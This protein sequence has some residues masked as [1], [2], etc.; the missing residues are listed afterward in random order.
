MSCMSKPP[1]SP[2]TPLRTPSPSP[3][4][5]C[6]TPEDFNASFEADISAEKCFLRASAESPTQLLVER[7]ARLSL[8]PSPVPKLDFDTDYDLIASPPPQRPNE[9]LKKENTKASAIPK[10]YYP[11]G[12]PVPEAV[13][14]AALDSVKQAFSKLPSGIAR[15]SCDL[16]QVCKAINF[17]VYCKRPLYEAIARASGHGSVTAE[18]PPITF[19]NFSSFWEEMTSK[20]HD[21]ASRFV[22]TLAAARCS[23]FSSSDVREYLIREDFTSLISDLISTHPGLDFLLDSPKFHRYYT[24]TVVVRIFWTVNRSFINDKIPIAKVRR[25]N[26]IEAIRKLEKTDDTNEISDFFSYAHFFVIYCTFHE[27]DRDGDMLLTPSDMRRYADGVLT[28]A[29]IERI[30]RGAGL[31]GAKT[32]KRRPVIGLC[33]FVAFMLAEVD[34]RNLASIDYWFRCLDVE[35]TG[36]LTAEEMRYFYAS[37]ESELREYELLHFSDV[38]DMLF[39]Y[40]APMKRRIALSD[41]RKCGLAHR[42]LNTFVNKEK[43]LEQE[44]TEGERAPRMSEWELFCLEEY[45]RMAAQDL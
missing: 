17:P 15:K 2:R 18:L 3:R 16:I 30:F 13:N 32:G 37:V 28:A 19:E 41:L 25:S 4:K 8:S 29:V 23:K 5:I 7:V 24:D 42:F 33:E 44:T 34:K 20:A 22:F 43:F 10:F 45:H 27:L 14:K 38:I 11:Y 6:R 26:L 36:V 39:D 9:I 1:L 35:G 31:K 40:A 12:K 21:E